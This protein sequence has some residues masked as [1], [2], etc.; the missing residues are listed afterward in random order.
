MASIAEIRQKFPQYS[1]MSDQALADAMHAKFYAD[2]PKD[3]FYKSVG[4]GASEP[5]EPRPV[6]LPSDADA[7]DR[8]EPG[9][10]P[11]FI[12]AVKQGW[13]AEPLGPSAATRA[14][15]ETAGPVGAFNK[16]VAEP[17]ATALEVVGRGG[18]AA[19]SGLGNLAG[20]GV[21]LAREAVPGIKPYVMPGQ[22]LQRDVQS[23][24]EAFPTAQ[25]GLPVPVMPEARSAM[26][27]VRAARA[28]MAGKQGAD[29]ADSIKSGLQTAKNVFVKP[30]ASEIVPITGDIPTAPAGLVKS[31]PA[32]VSAED[33][34]YKAMQQAGWTPERI[35]AKLKQ[36]GPNATL[37][38]V[39]PFQGMQETA[40]QTPAG[41][42]RAQRVLGAR[43]AQKQ[44]SLL[45][46]VENNLS[47][48]NYYA[49]LEDLQESRS[50]AGKADREDALNKTGIIKSDVI[51]RMLPTPEFQQGIRMGGKIAKLEEARTGVP[52]PKS[53]TWFHGADFDDPNIKIIDT[54]TLRMLDAGKQGMQQ[55][56]APFRNKYTGKL[57]NLGPYEVEVNKALK[58]V[59]AEMRKASEPY[60]K[61]L[62]TWGDHS[63]NM[64]ALSM[65]RR[66]LNQDP[67]VNAKVIAKMTPAQKEFFQIGLA[68]D[69]AD[70]IK[71]NSTRAL[72]ALKN[73]DTRA[74]LQAG[75]PDKASYN[76]FRQSALRAAAKTNTY[77]AATKGSQ[78]AR[79]AMGAIEE[80]A[81]STMAKDVIGGSI[82]LA[83]GNH[84]G[85]GRRLANRFLRGETPE[86]R[87]PILDQTS[88]ALHSTDPVIQARVLQ[89]LRA[90]SG[91][92]GTSGLLPPQGLE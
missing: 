52:V 32:A 59:T 67:E 38:D 24:L 65:G 61:Y 63:S 53:E 8:A 23:L 14:A 48:K 43:E 84:I 87:T 50:I 15:L 3:Q 1:D 91:I 57:E 68:R 31:A 66:A 81:P 39:F 16:Y 5:T 75:F 7:K 44:S 10:A 35:E 78:T 30:T 2:M 21:D 42:M 46:S 33:N 72:N 83:T 88:A 77:N 36:L 20:Q 45:K 40:A 73:P 69:L 34:L 49:S 89:R 17:A 64:D 11:G 86:T 22:Q 4:F 92:S 60:A 29:I 82:D 26:A 90:K 55:I 54:P 28:E 79:R 25:V 58:A 56:L 70:D 12:D 85:L 27:L 19:L 76:R 37:A 18:M 41:A 74:I 80:E 71:Q 13:G 47:D 51:Q 62:N 6:A 9:A